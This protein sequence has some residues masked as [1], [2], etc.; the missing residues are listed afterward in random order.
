MTARLLDGRRVLEH[1]AQAVR[2]RADRLVSEGAIRPRLAVIQFHAE[3]PGAVY[4]SRLA[5]SAESAGIEPMRILAPAGIVLGELAAIVEPLNRDASVA[6]IVL[7]QPVPPPI[8]REAAVMLVDPAKDVDGAHPLTA[9]RLVRGASTFVP[10]TALAVMA[11]LRHYEIPIAGRRAVVIGRS[12]VVGRPVAGLLLE[13]DATVVVCHTKTSDLAGETRRAEILV[14]AA[15]APGLVQPDMV[16]PGAVIVDAGYTTTPAG[17]RGDVAFDAVRD[18]VAAI[19]PVPGGV[20][21]V[22]P[23]MVVE[24]TVRAAEGTLSPG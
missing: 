13:A 17:P 12:A 20:G 22:A 5:S 23:M 15:G 19:T 2:E 9:G 21:R 7:V 18:M 11:V 4:A 3:G 10:A 24:Q 8:D 16:A 6:G 1:L 14:T